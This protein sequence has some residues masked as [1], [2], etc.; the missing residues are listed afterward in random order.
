MNVKRGLIRLWVL[1]SA[2]WSLCILSLSAADWYHA[3]SY[4]YRSWGFEATTASQCKPRELNGIQGRGLS[5]GAPPRSVD[6]GLL[7]ELRRRGLL[8]PPVQPPS[9]L[10][11][12]FDCFSLVAPDR[13]RYLVVVTKGKW[14]EEQIKD[15]AVYNPDLFPKSNGTD[16]LQV[17]LTSKDNKESIVIMRRWNDHPDLASDTILIGLGLFVPIAAFGLGSA[18]WWV[19]TG[20]KA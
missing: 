13:S 6:P 1:F 8:P 18:V 10:D 12:E 4:W 5:P 7:Q 14:N 20:F 3:A 15:E 17:D 2:I 9:T 11:I 16:P 19:A